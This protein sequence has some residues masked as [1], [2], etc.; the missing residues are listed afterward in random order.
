MDKRNI[1]WGSVFAVLILICA[2]FL[3]IRNGRKGELYAEIYSEGALVKEIDDISGQEL[4]K[5]TIKTDNGY[6]TVCWQN[7][8]I[9]I[10][11]A[12]CANHDCINYG[13]LSH[14]GSIIC[15]PHRLAVTVKEKQG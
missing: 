2:G 5:F 4:E 13:R 1:I 15:A 9:W 12:D 3:L 11:D 14:E 6:N 8:E 7:N 10:S